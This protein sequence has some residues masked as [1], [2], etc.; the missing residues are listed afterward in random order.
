MQPTN[1]YILYFEDTLPG[2]SHYTSSVGNNNNLKGKK[3]ARYK[4][5]SQL[6]SLI[7]RKTLSQTIESHFVFIRPENKYV[8]LII[9]FFDTGQ[10]NYKLPLARPTLPPTFFISYFFC[11]FRQQQKNTQQFFDGI[12]PSLYHS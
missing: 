11:M 12:N 3:H 6:A 4:D 7:V 5:T 10:K 8:F 2:Q 1:L 9:I